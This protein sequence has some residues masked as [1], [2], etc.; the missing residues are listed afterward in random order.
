[1][2][3]NELKVLLYSRKSHRKARWIKKW[4]RHIKR[5]YLEIGLFIP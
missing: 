4:N 2:D 1:M 3:Y 5:K